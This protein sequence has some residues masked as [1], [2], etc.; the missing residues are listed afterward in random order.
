MQFDGADL[1]FEVEWIEVLATHPDNPFPQAHQ[2]GEGRIVLHGAV[3]EQGVIPKD[4]ENTPIADPA[5]VK[6]F[7]VLRFDEER[8]DG[9]FELSLIGVFHGVKDADYI[10]MKIRY[11]SS[12]VMF[13]EFG[14]VSWFEDFHKQEG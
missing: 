11:S 2:S 12:T 7:E 4:D 10:E 5:Q 14:E 9:G 6:G 8:K 3:I 13:G 1:V